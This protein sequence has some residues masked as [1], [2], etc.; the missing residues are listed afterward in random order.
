MESKRLCGAGCGWMTHLHSYGIHTETCTVV[1]RDA[2][3]GECFEGNVGLNQGSI[4]SLLLFTAVMDVV[5]SETRS[6]L[7]SD[8]MYADDLVLMAPTMEPPGRCMTEWR[9]IY[10]MPLTF[11]Y[12]LKKVRAKLLNK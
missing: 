11:W 1:R 12:F 5:S 4:L 3:L 9:Y 8:L 7:P 10:H 2:G 6:G